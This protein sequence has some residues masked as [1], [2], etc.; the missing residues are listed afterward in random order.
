VG[1]GLGSRGLSLFS[2]F[3]LETDT[4]LVKNPIRLFQTKKEKEREEEKFPKR[5]LS[6]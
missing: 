3:I 2:L 5:S 1:W 6:L 4:P